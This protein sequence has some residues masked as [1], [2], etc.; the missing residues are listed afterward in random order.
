MINAVDLVK[1]YKG[2]DSGQQVAALRGC[3]FHVKQGE[4]VS[5]IGP[6]GAGKTTLLRLLGGIEKPS[7]GQITLDNE[8]IAEK[9]TS[10][11]REIRREKIGFVSQ[12]PEDNL[13]YGL[14]VWKNL[15]LAMRIGYFPRKE[16]RERGNFL[17][18]V[19]D[20]ETM[21]D[22]NVAFLSGGEKMRA[23]LAIAVA[24]NP[25]IVLADEPTGQLDSLRTLAIRKFLRMISQEWKVAVIVATHD[26]RFRVGVDRTL[27][28]SDGRLVR[29]E[30]KFEPE[31]VH[32]EQTR[33]IAHIDSTGFIQIPQNFLRKLGLKDEVEL[34]LDSS[35]T[36]AT[37]RHPDGPAPDKELP[38]ILYEKPQ[39]ETL[40][41]EI[42]LDRQIDDS[43]AEVAKL[44]G[45]NVTYGAGSSRVEALRDI[46][47]KIAEGE[48]T[49][50]VG[51]SGSGKSTLLR[52]LAGLESPT[53]GN[54]ALLNQTLTNMADSA[55]AAFRAQNLGLMVQE[56][57]LHPSFSLIDN[58]KLPFL[59]QG[60][61]LEIDSS[62][63]MFRA[64]DISE[65]IGSYPLQLS[66]GEKQRAGLVV[67][68]TGGPK[69]I[70]LDEP[71][72]HVESTLALRMIDFILNRAKEH[73]LTVI[74][75]THDLTL[76]R[77]GM[78][79]ISL[80]S[81]RKISDTRLDEIT[82]KEMV[83]SFFG[84]SLGE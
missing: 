74:L 8:S 9:S 28:I 3:D 58:I 26:L 76:L 48:I 14:S 34:E 43:A 1:I 42:I 69:M 33:L 72:A 77:P 47:L 52:I 41:S 61:Q 20:L 13:V 21:R 51:P 54:V 49:A 75:A 81:G 68:L 73:Q 64:L 45:V 82:H 53:A 84:S 50:I 6:S 44:E 67:A 78:H 36:F 4:F 55:R 59:L 37:F 35:G 46:D 2:I 31:V 7:S 12:F 63:D 15:E 11:L 25:K 10:Q 24:K 17:L 38:D 16:I 23:S 65:K 40:E 83:Q 19:F 79:L 56:T 27:T 30:G 62:L 29:I 66:G 18:Q 5:V 71:T 70:L 32:E 80:D 60:K 57:N 39:E 22:R